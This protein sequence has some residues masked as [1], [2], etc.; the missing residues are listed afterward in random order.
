MPTPLELARLKRREM[1][2]S[3]IKIKV[4]DPVEKLATNPGNRKLAIA[5]K[6]FD[7]EGSGLDPGWKSRIGAC[8]ITSCA[9]HA[10][11]PYQRLGRKIDSS[12]PQLSKNQ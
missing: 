6:C 12:V 8:E 10:V 4:L 9:L 11:R 2:E 7:C 5:A 3:G 1:A